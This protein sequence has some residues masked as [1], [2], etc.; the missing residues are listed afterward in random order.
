MDRKNMSLKFKY[1]RLLKKYLN[2]NPSR[3][4][5]ANPLSS[6]WVHSLWNQPVKLRA[7]AFTRQESAYKDDGL[8]VGIDVLQDQKRRGTK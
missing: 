6:A 5:T 4:W 3:T 7:K 1:L 2:R 8:A